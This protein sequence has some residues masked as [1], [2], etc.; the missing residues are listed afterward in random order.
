MVQK[1]NQTDTITEF[2]DW[3]DKE[4]KKQQARKIVA[5]RWYVYEVKPGYKWGDEY[6]D[7]W[8]PAT[9]TIVSPYFDTEEQAW[10][11][12]GEHEPDNGNTLHIA[13]QNKRQWTETFEEWVNY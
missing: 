6:D 9:S 2:R 12:Y 5:T 4:H 11:W 10:D 13:S 1:K 3:M 7:Y 8:E